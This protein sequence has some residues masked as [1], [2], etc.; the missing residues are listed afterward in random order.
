MNKCIIVIL[1]FTLNIL[2]GYTQEWFESKVI[3]MESVTSIQDDITNLDF[4]LSKNT[5]PLLGA[6]RLALSIK[7][8]RMFVLELF[9]LAIYGYIFYFTPS[10]I[11]RNIDE[12]WEFIPVATLLVD[13][14]KLQE[15]SREIYGEQLS[16][17]YRYNLSN[18][19]VQWMQSWESSD[20]LSGAGIGVSYA[21]DLSESTAKIQ[22]LQDGLKVSVREK[23]TQQIPTKPLRVEGIVKMTNQP[24]FTK[25]GEYVHAKLKV[26][27]KINNVQKQ[28]IF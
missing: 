23:L 3:I 17:I 14:I 27:I 25:S 5:Q 20:I 26:R 2:Q 8:N 9:E 4:N 13:D 28:Q 21:K 22:A 12:K 10:D 6:K 15:I 19:Q 11:L 24:F 7:E 18:P 16:V 1:F